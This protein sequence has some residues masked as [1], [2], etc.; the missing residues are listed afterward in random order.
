MK[1]YHKR[2][3]PF[4]NFHTLPWPPGVLINAVVLY[5]TGE[6]VAGHRYED[7]DVYVPFD[8]LLDICD[9]DNKHCWLQW[10]DEVFARLLGVPMG[11]LLS[12]HKANMTL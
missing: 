12:P 6:V 8:K 11:G 9:Y 7:H 1:N 4:K 3:V 2:Q 5:S 10:R